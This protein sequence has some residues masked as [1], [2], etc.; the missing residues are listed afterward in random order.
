[1]RFMNAV[2]TAPNQPNAYVVEPLQIREGLK[3]G[4][5]V[6]DELVLT[7]AYT[8]MRILEEALAFDRSAQR[9]SVWKRNWARWRQRARD[10]IGIL[11]ALMFMAILALLLAVVGRLAGEPFSAD[12]PNSLVTVGAW[13]EGFLS[14]AMTFVAIIVGTVALD[15][16]VISPYENRAHDRMAA[17][18]KAHILCIWLESHTTNGFLLP[19]AEIVCPHGT[20][21]LRYGKHALLELR[22]GAERR[23][24]FLSSPALALH[25]REALQTLTMLLEFAVRSGRGGRTTVSDSA[26]DSLERPFLSTGA[27]T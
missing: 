26:L 22:G 4:A 12:L 14:G 24:R 13:S 25:Y 9:P 19:L 21:D 20:D 11:P 17:Q 3:G 16:L 5:S 15:K 2:N 18:S 27:K 7:R 10:A 1:M 8:A 23:D 6:H